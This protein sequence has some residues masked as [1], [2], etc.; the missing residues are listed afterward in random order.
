MCLICF[1][2][3]RYF[4]I[5]YTSCTCMKIYVKSEVVSS[6]L[7][8]FTIIYRFLCGF[9][10]VYLCQS[11]KIKPS[12]MYIA[13]T[14]AQFKID[15]HGCWNWHLYIPDGFSVVQCS[16]G[17]AIGI[18]FWHSFGGMKRTCWTIGSWRC[19]LSSEVVSSTPRFHDNL[20]VPLWVYMRLPVPEHQNQTNKYV[21][22]CMRKLTIAFCSTIH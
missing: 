21:W 7:A 1:C 22:R 16:H 9:I 4:D 2:G 14:R 5:S 8:G 17:H 12:N 20:S 15:T 6:I 10:C 18:V 13:I 3:W 11:I 19:C